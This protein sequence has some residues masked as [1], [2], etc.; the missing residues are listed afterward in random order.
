MLHILLLLMATWYVDG[1]NGSDANAGTSPAT[2]FKTLAKAAAE[3]ASGDQ[4]NI[5]ATGAYPQSATVTLAAGNVVWIGANASGTVDGT[6]AAITTTAAID[7]FDCNGRGQLR[8]ENLNLTSTSATPGAC[9]RSSTGIVA[10]FDLRTCLLDGFSYGVIGNLTNSRYQFQNLLIYESEIRNCGYAIDNAA[11]T[12]FEGCYLHGNTAAAFRG[13]TAGSSASV[14]AARSIFFGNAHAVLGQTAI[15]VRLRSCTLVG[16][17]G[18]AILQGNFA[19]SL[20]IQNTLIETTSGYAI[21]AAV[22]PTQQL[23]FGNAY[24]ANSGGNFNGV[25]AG[26]GDIALTEEPCNNPA[27]GD[28]GLN[29]TAGGGAAC[30]AAGSPGAFPGGTTIGYPDIG[31]VQ[32][33]D[34]AGALPPP[35]PTL[36]VAD[37]GDGT[38]ATATLAGG[39]AGASNAVYVAPLPSSGNAAYTQAATIAGNGTANLGLAKGSYL[40]YA[41]ASENALYAPPSNTVSFRVT[42][43]DE[44]S[45]RAAVFNRLASDPAVQAIAGNPARIYPIKMAQEHQRPGI[46]YRRVLRPEGHAHYLK[47]SAGHAMAMFRLDCLADKYSDADTLAEAV[48]QSLDGFGPGTIAGVDVRSVAIHDECD[49]FDDPLDGGD[50]GVYVITLLYSIQYSESIPAPT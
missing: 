26:L 14:E 41:V 35:A 37:H 33:Q 1:L 45:I 48:R 30:R 17:T 31:A 39:D 5:C 44:T 47:G 25:S 7:L 19:W 15:S 43:A 8:F 34:A 6:R 46:V 13:G 10:S 28:F 38:G 9:F 22:A 27:G 42:N 49:D 29:N 24:R 20:I 23:C 36:T 4:V 2:A 16:Q 12:S 11:N 40:A 18:D 21:N 50:S 32:H 3:A